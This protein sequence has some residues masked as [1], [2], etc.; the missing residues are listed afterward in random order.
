MARL[1]K[2]IYTKDII[3]K[4]LF[5]RKVETIRKEEVFDGSGYGLYL[6]L[7]FIAEHNVIGIMEKITTSDNIWKRTNFSTLLSNYGL[8]RE[9]QGID[10]QTDYNQKEIEM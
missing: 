8:I 6:T 10:S 3:K 2:V 1:I 7:N 4:G 9:I 5:S